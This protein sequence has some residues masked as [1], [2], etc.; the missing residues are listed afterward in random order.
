VRIGLSCGIFLSLVA[1]L[2][3]ALSILAYIELIRDL[4]SLESLPALLDPPDGLLLQPTRLYD[5]T[6]SH[7]L[8]T[9]QNPAA[10]ERQYLTLDTR[11]PNFFPTELVSTTLAVADPDFWNHAGYSLD[12]LLSSGHPTLAQWLV[13]DQLFYEE[14]Q[15]LRRNL[16][17]RVLAAQITKRYGRERVLVWFLNSAN[18]GRLAFG[19]DAA[20]RVYFGKPASQLSLAEAALLAATMQ[21]PALNPQDAPEVA[22]EQGEIILQSMVKDG[23]ITDTQAAQARQSKPV[24]VPRTD[25][26]PNPAPVF[27][28]LTLEQLGQTVSL[29]R[30]ER[31]GFRV[32]TS[33]D[34]DLQLQASCVQ[35][36]YIAR[37][38]GQ[39]E[40]AG[41][42]Q[43]KAARLLA[44][45]LRGDTIRAQG[46]SGNLI[47]L[48]HRSGQI[49]A[50]VGEDTPGL[51]PAHYP[52]HPA[53]TLWTPFI[54][55]TGFT[56]GL[57]P[58][59]LL[60]D[61][62]TYTQVS[63]NLDGNFHGPLRLRTALA[64]DDI[65]PAVAVMD[66]VGA[67]NVWRMARQLGLD[68]ADF[69]L[70]E[71][72]DALLE[73]GGVTL[74]EVSRAFGAFANL[75]LLVGRENSES[76]SPDA[77]TVLKLE[78]ANG[79]IW[80]DDTRTQIRPVVS[81]QLAYLLAHILSDEPARWPSLGHPNPLEIGRP[82]AAK[83]GR[84]LSEQEA[85]AIGSTPN[86]T[87]GVWLGSQE[88][89]NSNR[90]SILNA[91]A[92]L[93]AIAQYASQ[94]TP[95]EGWG[96]PAG[97]STLPVCDP[98]GLLPTPEC[99]AVVNEIFL[100]GNEPTQADT[101][102]R[103]LQINRE[104]GLLATVFTPPEQVEERVYLLLP[105][106][107]QEWARQAGL[108]IPPET[109]DVILS[110]ASAS[111]DARISSP[112]MFAYVR[113]QVR[114]SGSAGGTG[115]KLYRLQVGQGLNPQ[116][117]I[118]VGQDRNSPAS[119]DL[120]SVWDTSGLSGLYSIQLTVIYQ[121]QRVQTDVIQVTIDNQPPEVSIISPAEGQISPAGEIL[122]QADV[123][124]DLALKNVEFL[125]DGRLV[126]ELAQ[127]PFALQWE[128]SPGDHTLQVRATDQAGN[129]G[130]VEITFHIK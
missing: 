38:E 95:S 79:K 66:Q 100:A 14:P 2:L 51:D 25:P 105:P 80:L 21:T 61:I 11:Q 31:G 52:G 109:F 113:G 8:L 76:P 22:I 81:P 108:P 71:A 47:I 110:S 114:V 102:Y 53:G 20:A 72:P 17:E 106:E 23:W 75:G 116:R 7:L 99:P 118:Q 111:P 84:T 28:K 90:V 87:L 19:A 3:G 56:R 44:T 129:T 77:I 43:C 16:R 88:T 27:L 36:V 5:R 65:A 33:M 83:L 46:L 123:R 37:L 40:P 92:L 48:D 74:L 98:S 55:L 62:P 125:V 130:Q 13:S 112:A 30:L 104:T 122:L 107:A 85:W 121:D 6:G 18:Y 115:F 10:A 73:E 64:N 124:D 57:G 94:N 24:P 50:L 86:L 103:R 39:A 96:I 128:G 60:W 59:S 41:G 127:T 91:A 58:A 12:G 49:L 89:V 93:H 120:L 26:A 82:F 35:Q 45:N 34:Y 119:D 97:I 9:L 117:W 63:Y 67:E 54:Y 29:D 78:D 42:E 101:L 69:P 4:P 32:I 15:G 126:S 1:L 70:G 68:G